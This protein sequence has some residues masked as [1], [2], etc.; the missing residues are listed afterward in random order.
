MKLLL[1]LLLLCFSLLHT[2]PTAGS[3]RLQT[4]TAI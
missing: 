4:N 3:R 1:L 2:P